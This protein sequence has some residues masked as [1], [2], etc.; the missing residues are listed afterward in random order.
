MEESKLLVKERQLVI[1]GDT[2]ANGIDFLPG[3]GS[4]RENKDIKSKFLGL[5]KIKDRLL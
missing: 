2:L 5:T 1:P 4:Y 3:S